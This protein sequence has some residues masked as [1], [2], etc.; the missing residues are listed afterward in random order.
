[1]KKLFLWLM[2][3]L[4]IAGSAND[5]S[6]RSK[7]K[8]GK[9]NTEQ[10]TD[11]VKKKKS[12]YDKLFKDKKKHTVS[13]GIITVHQYENK[14]YLEL[15]IELMGR[16]FL[17][18][19]AVT[20]ASDISL[21]GT[22]A[23]QSRYLI[24][25]KT[26]S[27][28][29]FRDPKYNVRINEQDKNQ[30]E[31]FTLSRSN[32][33]Y[34]AFPIEGYTSDSTA[35][36]FNA[37]SY[38]SCSN[39]DVLNLSGRS[40]GGMLTIINASPQSK[41]SFVD[42][43]EAF[44][45]CISITQNCTAKLSISI[46][47][48]VS[49]EQP[50]LTM[51]VQTTL[52]LLSKDKMN[53]REANPRVGTGFISYTDYRNEKRSKKGYY[54]TRRNISS[55]QPIIFYLDTLIQDS[56]AKAIQKSA[57]E[58]NIVFEKLGL[59]KPI[60]IK[61]YEKDST[62]RANNPMIN[63]IGFLNNNN[64][65]VTAYNVT[66]LRTGEILSTKMGVPRDLAFSVRRNGVYQMA[67][68]DPRFRTYYIADEVICEN[69]TA[70]MLKAFG[71]SLGLTTNL[72]GSA[73]YS[74]QELRS[75]K[76]TQEYG[77]TASVMDNIVYN[78]LAQPGDKEK[79]VV[80]VVNK[81]GVCDAFTLKYLYAP[82]PTSVKESE[83]LKK[84]AMEHDGDPR[85]FY[86]KRTPIYATDPRCQNNDLGNDPIASIDAQI[87]HV[88][89][90]VKNSPDWFH[91]DNIPNDYRELFPDF[92]IIELINKT[93]SPVSSYIGGIY[94]NEAS[95]S[96][97]VPS[98]QSV[99]ADVQKK[100]LQKI[101]STFYDLSWL[102]SNKDF[103]RLGGANPD[104]STWIYNNGYPMMSLMYRLMRMGLSVEKS[105]MPY[106]QEAFLN[107]IEKQL[108]KETINGKPLSSSMVSQISVY[109]NSLKGMCPTL[110]ALDKAASTSVTSIAL[111]EQREY[112][113]N[114]LSLL[115]NFIKTS[116]FEEAGMEPTTAINFYFGTDIEA[117]CYD[118]LKTAR[119]YLIQ[120]RLYARNEIERG[121]CD[122]L[123]A[124]I[125]RVL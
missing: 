74:P 35:V 41:T 91:D 108:F 20:E 19:S 115:T 90:I 80:L 24:I 85:Y 42:S 33:I 77:I 96:S 25:D 44:E 4:L 86:G 88:K 101:F 23:A 43:I 83:T 64:S 50:E 48:F 100:V 87:S 10:K 26:D 21:A 73:A 118:K 97:N 61:P 40:Y 84:W 119:N 2:A 6:A 116:V 27:L 18:N 56:W 54:V 15:P 81:P 17:V 8:K 78:Y 72:A 111:N 60:L 57:D 5:A 55:Q 121:K 120:A 28:V 37:T 58:W 114:S 1:M 123:I 47:G 75:P 79:G 38:F 13:K 62:F 76:F 39:K 94:I 122:Y 110:K 63:T 105:A 92:V 22:K 89:Y 59:G 113:L 45:N 125:N 66:D 53:T 12:V 68:V 99:P 124:M 107:D 9:A 67:E 65:E 3:G 51:A 52:A 36:V 98:Y 30:K 71:L 109:I 117:I 102:D 16:D 103:L 34:K 112:K 31:A 14:I 46:M 95:E 70:R 82:T 29:L 104:I 69:L 11:S 7:K 93:L 32:A 49:K 106:T